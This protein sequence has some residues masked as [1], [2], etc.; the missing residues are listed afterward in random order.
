M[1][2]PLGTAP[3]AHELDDLD[4][5]VADLAN[6]GIKVTR[7][8][9]TSGVLVLSSGD[10]L[11]GLQSGDVIQRVGGQLIHR[12]RAG[13]DVLRPVGERVLEV[14]DRARGEAARPG[15]ERADADQPVLEPFFA[16]ASPLAALRTSARTPCPAVVTNIATL[17]M[18]PSGPSGAKWIRA[19]SSD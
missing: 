6:R 16:Q 5:A 10:D 7:L 1:L 9:M 12:Q 17:S 11:K 14:A 3:R 2:D 15:L 4:Q 8:V 13:D 18:G 19:S